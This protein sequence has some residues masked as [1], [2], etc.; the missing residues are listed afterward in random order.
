VR[1]FDRALK[2]ELLRS[3][4]E[5]DREFRRQTDRLAAFVFPYRLEKYT[6]F[7]YRYLNNKR[8]NG[9]LSSSFSKVLQEREFLVNG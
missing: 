8:T 3:V 1:P 7:R 2:T 4:N 6:Q 9:S 5:Y